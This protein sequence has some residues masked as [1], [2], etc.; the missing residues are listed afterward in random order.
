MRHDLLQPPPVL[1]AVR[2]SQRRFTG[3]DD[4]QPDVSLRSRM[5]RGQRATRGVPAVRRH[6]SAIFWNR[7]K[8]EMTA[9]TTFREMYGIRYPY[10]CI[11]RAC[12]SLTGL[13]SIVS[14]AAARRSSLR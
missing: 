13:L 2:H 6:L 8:E 12:V 3:H 11:F 5:Q 1:D 4:L 7:D 9:L 10:I 14:D